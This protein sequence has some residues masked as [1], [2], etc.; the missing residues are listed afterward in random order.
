M[1]PAEKAL[2][3]RLVLRNGGDEGYARTDWR[4]VEAVL[5]EKRILIEDLLKDDQELYMPYDQGFNDAIGEV[6][7][8]LNV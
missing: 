5:V 3:D 1:T 8:I 7:R 4:L 2:F 6:L